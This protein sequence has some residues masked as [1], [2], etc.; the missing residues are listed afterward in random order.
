V[1]VLKIK[2]LLSQS[3]VVAVEDT[4]VGACVLG[5]AVYGWYQSST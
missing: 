4:M 3:V 1:A 5:S 2:G